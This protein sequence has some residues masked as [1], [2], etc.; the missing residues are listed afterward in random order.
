MTVPDFQSL[1]RPLLECAQDGREV[2]TSDCVEVIADKL[3]LSQEDR[4]EMLP[5]G[6]QLLLMNRVHWA[7]T[8]LGKAGAIEATK[9]GHFKLTER[10]H[11]LIKNGP[12]KITRQ[13]LQNYDEFNA[14]ND[15]EPILQN[16][17]YKSEGFDYQEASPEERIEKAYAELNSQLK[18]EILQNLYEVTPSTFEQIIVD[19]LIA[20]GYGGGR[21]EMGRALGK[22]NDG[23][24]DGVIKEDE[25]GLDVV[26]IQAKKYKLDT[27]ISRPDIQSFVGSLEGFNAT[28]GVFVTTGNFANTVEEYVSRIHK[29]IVL[30]DGTKLASLMI[31][32]NVGVRVKNSYELKYLDEDYFSE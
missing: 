9:R 12:E 24:V 28:K 4:E 23:G 27:S 22:T 7:R 6:R 8:Y 20:M 5:S 2:R 17:T 21:T 10:G 18:A 30:I 29:R 15:L 19:L 31:R 32:H 26:Y 25:L 11:D 13:T 14:W 1:M 3:E 16:K